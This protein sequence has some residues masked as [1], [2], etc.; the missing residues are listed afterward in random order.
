MRRRRYE[1][2]LPLLHNDG[3]PVSPGKHR[4][5]R[6]ELFGRYGAV[7][8]LPGMV[9][10]TWLHAGIRYEDESIRLVMDVANTSIELAR[11]SGVLACGGLALDQPPVAVGRQAGPVLHGAPRPID[12]DVLDVVGGGQADEDAAVVGR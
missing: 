4:Q 8:S 10:G 6:E 1:M 3:R 11:A 7:S 9:H 2:L 12:G 5:T